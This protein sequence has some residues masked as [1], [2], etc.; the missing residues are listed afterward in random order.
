MKL[1]TLKTVLDQAKHFLTT[2]DFIAIL[3]HFAFDGE[4]VVAYND[5]QAC[6][7]KLDSE[8]HCTIPGN[9]LIRLISTMTSEDIKIIENKDKTYVNISCG[10]AKAKL[11]ILPLEN[12]VF[13]LP[14][15]TERPITFTPDFL[16]G[17]KKCLLS[18]SANPTRP[19]FNGINFV[20]ESDQLTLYSSD[21]K[22]LS[23]FQVK[24]KF[25]VEALDTIQAIVPAFFCEKLTT[26]YPTLS[27]KNTNI[28][29]QFDQQWVIANLS[30]NY[31]FSRVIDRKAPD[32]EGHIMKYVPD[33]NQLTLFDIPAELEAILNRAVLFLDPSTGIYESEF[34]V[35]KTVVQ[36]HTTST[37]GTSNDAFQIPV[38][39]GQFTFS[40]DPNLLLRAFKVCK[41]LM[42]KKN[43]I[44]LQNEQFVH[45]IAIRVG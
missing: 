1:Q 10:N 16:E 44:I 41:K 9:L 22:T 29:C 12:F 39:L 23:R 4:T 21:G 43:V 26:L 15:T 20:I 30:G 8:L 34:I 5:V 28:E 19:E 42:I 35:N 36:V 45:L 33:L 25:D 37:L 11:P 6:K 2:Q 3:Q 24:D 32:C 13:L 17:I 7:I 18:V 38:D 27:G 40:V 14:E 31:L